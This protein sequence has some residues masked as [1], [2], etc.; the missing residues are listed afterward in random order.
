MGYLELAKKTL[1][2]RSP[3]AP[4]ACVKCGTDAT[5]YTPDGQPLC[6]TH[7]PKS[8]DGP[9]VRFAVDQLGLAI[10]GRNAAVHQPRLRE[11]GK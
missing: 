6:E 1:A 3:D 5:Y 10:T 4:G 9:L 11:N 7:A 8:T 2:A